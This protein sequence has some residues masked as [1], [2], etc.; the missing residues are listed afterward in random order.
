VTGKDA[1]V[2]REMETRI[3]GIEDL[4]RELKDLG[5][6]IPAVEKNA[7]CILSF[8]FALKFGI[9]DVVDLEIGGDN[10]WEK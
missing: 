1:H 3:E 2:L 6:G 10:L 5:K 8:I 9:S 7:R 4:A